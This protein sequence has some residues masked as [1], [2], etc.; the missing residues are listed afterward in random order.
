MTDYF[1]EDANRRTGRTTNIILDAVKTA[2]RH[3]GREIYPRD[4]RDT[5][6]SN[7]NLLMKVSE[8]LTVLNIE[9]EINVGKLYVTVKPLGSVTREQL[10][11]EAHN[12]QRG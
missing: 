5:E 12:A 11:D 1:H 8:I 6:T 3:A 9:H 7:K 4:H 2:I 10:S